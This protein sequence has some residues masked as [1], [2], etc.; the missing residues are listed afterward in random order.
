MGAEDFSAA[1]VGL[2][3]EGRSELERFLVQVA[4]V[5]NVDTYE[6]RADRV[7]LMTVHT[8]K[9]LEF[10]EVFLV[11]L[12]EGVFPHAASAYDERGV[13]EERRLFYVGMTRAM[14]R[15]TLT[16]AAERRRFG[17][18]SINAPSRFLREIPESVLAGVDGR[19]AFERASGEPALDYS[20]GQPEAGAQ[21]GIAR[22]LRVRHPTFGYGTVLEVI[23]AGAGQK[24]CIRFDRAG[25]KTVM[26]RFAN[27]EFG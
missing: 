13:E 21:Q 8:A 6:N 1:N 3:E 27:L 17:S 15:L 23:G 10:H 19:R 12:E 24:L 11:G 18:R 20:Y 7:S 26:V 16:C 14:E 4:L 25:A 9:G 5:T 22:G 2:E